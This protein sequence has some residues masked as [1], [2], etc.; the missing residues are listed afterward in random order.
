MRTQQWSEVEQLF[1]RLLD[2]AEDERQLV[3]RQV[4]TDYPAEVVDEVEA[5]L[6]SLADPSGFT[7]NIARYADAVLETLQPGDTVGAWEVLG[8]LGTGGQGQVYRVRRCD[9]QFEQEGALKILPAHADRAAIRR[10]LRERQVLAELR[11]PAIPVLLDGGVFESQP[12]LVSELISG[13]TL[14][15][16]LEKGPMTAV[17]AV[18]LVLQLC[19]AVS[20]AHAQLVVHRDIKPQ[21]IMVRSSEGPVLLDFG[22]AHR[23]D[24]SASTAN[25]MMTLAYAAPEQLRDERATSATDVYQLAATLVHCLTGKPP[26][27]ARDP[28]ALVH[29]ILHQS[30][31]VTDHIPLELA[32]IIEVALRK[33]SADRYQS[34]ESF[35]SDL[36]AWKTGEPVAA[37]AGGRWYRTRKFVRRHAF[38]TAWTLMAFLGIS[39]GFLLAWKKAEEAESARDEAMEAATNYQAMAGLWGQMLSSANPEVVGKEV[40]TADDI[41]E[42]ALSTIPGSEMPALAKSDLMAQLAGIYLNRGAFDKAAESARG[43]LKLAE[44]LDTE[45]GL[46]LFAESHM[47]LGT[48]LKMQGDYAVSEEAVRKALELLNSHFQDRPDYALNNAYATNMLATLRY[49]QGD[50]EEAREL[51]QTNVNDAVGREDVPDWLQTMIVS[52]LAELD[53][54]MEKFTSAESIY[55][56]QLD[57]GDQGRTDI[58]LKLGRL[59]LA[60]GRYGDALTTF[61]DA[62]RVGAQKFEETHHTMMEARWLILVA[63]VM[64]NSSQNL[65]ALLHWRAQNLNDIPERLLPRVHYW[66][67][68]AALARGRWSL[69]TEHLDRAIAD[70]ALSKTL[71]PMVSLLNA[72]SNYKLE[73]RD[74]ALE[75]ARASA[76]TVELPKD[77][78]V[79]QLSG[80]LADRLDGQLSENRI[81]AAQA[82]LDAIYPDRRIFQQILAAISSGQ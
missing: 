73:N 57:K 27:L 9:G 42:M 7:G 80:L 72:F 40:V 11:H 69:A 25:A 26:F 33:E 5:L 14:A 55:R 19:D 81:S 75:L 63:S 74:R 71:T 22:T 76:A 47:T 10:F 45:D 4:R 43:A 35:R 79:L 38:A 39:A 36:N 50:L 3:L 65:D 56:A 28:A 16:V 1:D 82:H 77:H 15:T 37:M 18:T 54:V 41:L 62:A 59:H 46:Y 68:H 52:N 13:V 70:P 51:H 24:R 78:T 61:K 20:H 17:E 60:E 34:V 8:A 23:M 64:E 29:D 53:V 6:E 21:N 66:I 31:Q 32:R 49:A 30:P 44:G 67:G 12:Y 48:A 2:V 58:Y